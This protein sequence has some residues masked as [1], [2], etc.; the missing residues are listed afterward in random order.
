MVTMAIISDG[1]NNDNGYDV[2]IDND[3]GCDSN[4]GIDDNDNNDPN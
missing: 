4:T 2:N 1:D 3:N